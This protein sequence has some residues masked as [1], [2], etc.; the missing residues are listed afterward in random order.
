M[1]YELDG[2]VAAEVAEGI[3]IEAEDVIRVHKEYR[4]A[5]F[6]DSVLPD[7]EGIIHLTGEVKSSCTNQ[8]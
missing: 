3:F 6:G 8:T 7:S 5:G 2:A 4:P 1:L